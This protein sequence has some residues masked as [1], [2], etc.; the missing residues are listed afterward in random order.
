VLIIASDGVWDV[1]D[2]VYAVE[3]ALCFAGP[4]VIP[5]C[6]YELCVYVYA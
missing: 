1:I 5:P 3:I 2:D 4:Q 6:T